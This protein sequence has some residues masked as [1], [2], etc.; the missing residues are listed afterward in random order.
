M[1]SDFWPH[2]EVSRAYGIFNEDLGVPTRA[3]FFLDEDGIVRDIVATESMGIG[4][5]IDAQLDA[6]RNLG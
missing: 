6:L 4:R 1:L 2:G 5:E 3:T